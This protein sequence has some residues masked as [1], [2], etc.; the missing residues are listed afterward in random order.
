M[1]KDIY[2]I[3]EMPN[4]LKMMAVLPINNTGVA[5][6][7]CTIRDNPIGNSKGDCGP[8]SCNIYKKLDIENGRKDFQLCC[9]ALGVQPSNVIT[10]RLTAFTNKVRVVDANTLIDYNI[11]DE[12]TA[13]RA[14][15]LITNSSD[16]TL[17]H[18]AADCAICFLVDPV[19]KACGCLHASWKGSLLGIIQ[20]EVQS[21]HTAYGSKT[22]DIIAVLMPSISVNAFEVGIDC[23]EQFAQA[24][25]GEFVD[26][27]SY[28]KPH[29][30]L[31]KVNQRI[32]LNCGLKEENVYVIDDLCTYRDEKF[33]HSFRRGPVDENGIHLNGMNGY[34]IR[35]K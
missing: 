34:F 28:E 30:D 2:K 18:Y 5:E 8:F 22:E 7:Y 1:K 32:L 12:P 10:N 27:T 25:F 19:K 29:V 6:A 24:G 23:A 3:V 9:E 35:I 14:D 31:P 17:Y 15:G 16:V 21:F 26:Y 13:P 33:F 4:G 11:Y 20:S